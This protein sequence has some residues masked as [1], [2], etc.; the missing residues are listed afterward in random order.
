MFDSIKSVKLS[1]KIKKVKKVKKISFGKTGFLV[2]LLGLTFFQAGVLIGFGFFIKTETHILEY[3]EQKAGEYAQILPTIKRVEAGENQPLYA[4]LP[5]DPPPPNVAPKS[6]NVP[7][8]MYHHVSDTWNVADRYS[9]G[10]TVK[11]AQ[12]EAQVKYLT[13]NGYNL[14]TLSDLY[15]SLYFGTTLP[16]KPIIL[17]F[18][19][20]YVDNYQYAFPILKKYRGRGT[21]F[22]IT[23]LSNGGY[24]TGDQ[25]KEMSEAGME[26]G[27]HTKNHIDLNTGDIAKLTVELGTSKKELEK[28][29]GKPIQFLCYPYGSYSKSTMIVA[30][31]QGYVMALTTK[32]GRVHSNGSP[33]ELTRVRVLPTTDI[34]EFR[35][36]VAF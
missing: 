26:I 34:S 5:L 24:M 13:E 14:I 29:T 35:R 16:P 9:Y 27:S 8:M 12:F 18:D 30:K 1:P 22:I 28:I 36:L 7:I 2:A 17:T 32:Y 19:D 31:S 20:G 25:I 33:F 21:F 15:R 6:V 11:P 3:S 10:L 4:T 23:S